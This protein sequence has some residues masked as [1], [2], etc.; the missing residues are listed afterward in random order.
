MEVP[1]NFFVKQNSEVCPE[2]PEADETC[3]PSATTSGLI[4][5]SAVGPRLEKLARNVLLPWLVAPTETTLF[6]FAGDPVDV[7]EGPLFP[8]E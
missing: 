8:A 4:L 6:A 7:G 1:L 3:S 2:P 5:P